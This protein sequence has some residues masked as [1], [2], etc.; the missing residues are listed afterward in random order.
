M[1]RRTLYISL[2]LIVGLGCSGVQTPK[3][4]ILRNDKSFGKNLTQ[5]QEY[6]GTM[7]VDVVV[8]GYRP[9]TD[10]TIGVVYSEDSVEAT[11]TQATITRIDPERT[12]L[13]YTG[14]SAGSA[15]I[16]P[17]KHVTRVHANGVRTYMSSGESRGALIWPSILGFMALIAIALEGKVND[18]QGCRGGCLAIGLILGAAALL[19]L[20]VASVSSGVSG[21]DPVLINEVISKVWTIQ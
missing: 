5:L 18:G 2:L 13:R 6:L 19:A 3:E 20:A 12:V 16:V 9:T 21:R 15:I 14:S 10:N 1:T 11:I 4:R 7:P 17:T 8:E